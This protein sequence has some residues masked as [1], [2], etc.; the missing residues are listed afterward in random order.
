[1]A[2]QKFVQDVAGCF[3]GPSEFGFSRRSWR[4]ISF[5]WLF[6]LLRRFVE[7]RSVKNTFKIKCPDAG[8]KSIRSVVLAGQTVSGAT[9]SIAVA[10]GFSAGNHGSVADIINLSEIAVGNIGWNQG[11]G[12]ITGADTPATDGSVSYNNRSEFNSASSIAWVDSGGNAVGDLSGALTLLGSQAGYN[13]GEAP[14]TLTFDI[15]AA[16]A[17]NWVD[18]GLGGLA[19]SSIDNGDGNGRFNL[20]SIVGDNGATN[21]EFHVV[22]EPSAGLVGG[23]ALLLTAVRRRRTTA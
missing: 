23:I 13:V 22:P 10:T 1:M 3:F 11:T 16:T 2:H 19:I 12:T 7:N 17:Q 18:F 8:T 14:A 21:I 20:I 5:S 4:S 15:D 9:V 6:R